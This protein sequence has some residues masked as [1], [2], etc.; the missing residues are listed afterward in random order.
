MTTSAMKLV[1]MVR[2]KNSMLTFNE[3]MEKLSS[4]VDEIVVLDNGSVDGTL[5]ACKKFSKIV[6]IIRRNDANDFHE[7][8]DRNLMLAEAQKRHAD[9]LILTDPDE[10]FEKHI[11]RE[12]ME[13]YMQSGYD[14]VTFRMCHFW[15][16]KRF[17]RF[18]R[19]WFLY[20]LRPQRQ[21]CRN[22]EGIRFTDDIIHAGLQ[23]LG[24]RVHVS[25]YRIKHYGYV[26][27]RNIDA[28]MPVFKAADPDHPEKYRS[29]DLEHKES[30]EHVLH[31]PFIELKNRAA[32]YAY[33]ACFKWLC[34]LLLFLV[35]VKRK[36]FHALKIFSR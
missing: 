32:N 20:T 35:T 11:T 9:W 26:S 23:G 19:D 33:I 17:C 6:T 13:R 8:R 3:S 34:D 31:Y 18:D 5:E 10:V 7:G 27:K 21:I 25:P 22:R 15:L 14:R 29:C 28:K 16:S 30:T 24:S 1:A 12:I 4:L 36:Y 2:A